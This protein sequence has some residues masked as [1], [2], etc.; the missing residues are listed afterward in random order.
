VRFI[1]GFYAQWE[2][3]VTNLEYVSVPTL[4]RMLR[5][6]V[7]EGWTEFSCHPG[8]VSPDFTSVYLQEREA[9]IRT[10]TAPDIR[11]TIVDLGIHLGNY[12]DYLAQETRY[13]S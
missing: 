10:L 1:G 6:E 7:G 12:T 13:I 3:M 8:Y 5:E 11:Q 9:E 4:Q 2:W